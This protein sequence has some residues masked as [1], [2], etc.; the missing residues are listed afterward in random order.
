MSL[1]ENDIHA[2]A[3]ER[4]SSNA[5]TSQHTRQPSNKSAPADALPQGVTN[6]LRTTTDFGAF[7]TAALKPPRLRPG[8]PRRRPSAQHGPALSRTSSHYSQYSRAE[9]LRSRA[10]NHS[11]REPSIP[12]A[13]PT[14]GIQQPTFDTR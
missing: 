14:P 5:S 11:A 13:W 1:K 6:M 12:G 7:D 3:R 9:S 10:S 8:G 4:R 2:I